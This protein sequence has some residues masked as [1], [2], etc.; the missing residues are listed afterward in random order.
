MRFFIALAVFVAVAVAAPPSGNLSQ[1]AF[2][3]NKIPQL[4]YKEIIK[5]RKCHSKNYKKISE[6]VL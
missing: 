6:K 3:T 2:A 5:I 4:I 1:D